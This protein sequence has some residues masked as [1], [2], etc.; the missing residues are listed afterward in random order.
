[1]TNL[2]YQI[3]DSVA[4]NLRRLMSINKVSEAEVSRQTHI[5]QP[6]IHKI[7]SGKTTDPRASTLIALADYFKIS[8]DELVTGVE[9]KRQA[10]KTTS[11]PIISWSECIN[12]QSILET[13][14]HSNWD[15][16]VVTQSLSE[17]CYAVLSKP[18]MEPRFPVGTALVIDPTMKPEDGDVVLAH[19]AN[20]SEA[21]LREISIDGPTVLLTT[22]YG[23]TPPHEMTTDI[24]IK[25]V[26]IRSI[27]SY[28]D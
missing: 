13:I 9:L 26:L 22:L 1:M 23:N 20:T 28:H 19:Y 17:A 16:W 15:K 4:H 18:C 6:T 14:T 25:G 24:A 10:S 2:D 3:S 27:F 11:I 12:A 5:P 7:V 21:T 8:I